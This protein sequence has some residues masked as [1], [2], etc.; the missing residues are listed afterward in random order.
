MWYKNSR[1]I[2]TKQKKSEQEINLTKHVRFNK[3]SRIN[4]NEW[5]RKST[6][7]YFSWI[8]NNSMLKYLIFNWSMKI[9]YVAKNYILCILTFNTNIK[10]LSD[11]I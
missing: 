1:I 4:K 11:M 7:K 9:Q 2:E 5:W 10:I 8:L 3:N 6:D